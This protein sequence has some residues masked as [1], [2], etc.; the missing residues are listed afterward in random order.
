M[1]K[2]WN[3]EDASVSSYCLKTP[4]RTFGG[5]L[6]AFDAGLWNS[7]LGESKKPELE[8]LAFPQ[9]RVLVL[10][11]SCW[12]NPSKQEV[13][14]RVLYLPASASPPGLQTISKSSGPHSWVNKR[15]MV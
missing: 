13:T 9:P 8:M 11:W 2:P 6:Q 3:S 7:P 1:F 15:I 14:P 10:P 4:L 5:D 12:A